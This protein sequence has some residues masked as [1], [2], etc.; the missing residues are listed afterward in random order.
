MGLADLRH[1]HQP[2]KPHE[3]RRGQ[4][5]PLQL[6]P[7]L[8]LQGRSRIY[9]EGAQE[10]AGRLLKDRKLPGAARFFLRL[11]PIGLLRRDPRLISRQK[12]LHLSSIEAIG[13]SRCHGHQPAR[14]KNAGVLCHRR[15]LHAHL[16]ETVRVTPNIQ[17]VA[18]MRKILSEI[19]FCVVLYSVACGVTGAIAG[20]TAGGRSSGRQQPRGP[21]NKPEPGR[22]LTIRVISVSGP[23][24]RRR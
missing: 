15:A 2:G 18:T 8:C 10:A 5:R 7:G 6:R 20:M 21:G 22:W 11:R 12:S 4:V 1:L 24:S 19:V 3:V 14:P 9:L 23:W 16:A 13:E 17:W